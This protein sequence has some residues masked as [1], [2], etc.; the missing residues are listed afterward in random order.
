MA[1]THVCIWSGTGWKHISA[2][3][4]AR[5]HP[6][7]TVSAHSGLFMCELCG[8]YVLLTDGDIQVRHFRHSSSE[9]SKDCPE[10]T[11]GTSFFPSYR[12]NEHELPIRIS[13]IQPKRINFE[14]GLIRVPEG[15]LK[16][17]SKIEIQP[18]EQPDT[19]FVYLGE[20]IAP[21][22]ITYVG[23]GSVPY[24]QYQITITDAERSIYKYWPQNVTG[25]NPEGSIFETDTGK[26]LPYDADVKVGD[27]YYLLIAGFAKPGGK[28]ISVQEVSSF[29]CGWRNWRLYRICADDYD[30]YSAR[31]FLEYHCRLTKYP[32]SLVPIW[33]VYVEDPYVMKHSREKTFMLVNGNAEMTVFP[34]SAVRQHYEAATVMEVAA[35]NRQQLISIVRS[36]IY[37]V[38]GYTYFWQEPLDSRNPL[39][40]VTAMNIDGIPL[41]VGTH[42]KLPKHCEIVLQSAY[43]GTVLVRQEEKVIEKRTVE[44]GETVSISDL[45]YGMEINV[46]IGLDLCWSCSF[47][48]EKHENKCIQEPYQISAATFIM[49]ERIPL[50]LREESET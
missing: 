6:G 4:A 8:Q 46:L 43:D 18:A 14:L 20:R 42:S 29:R 31:F 27:E 48:R 33:P 23:I 17:A 9:K 25:I 10:R 12:K 44:A 50:L 26:K 22:Q 16:P 49:P 28:H 13:V 21:D 36:G 24:R 39:P 15:L 3:E 5:Q 40:T 30:E 47:T 38:L 19:P 37:R 7:G 32:S 1:L 45:T 41:T 11:A 34:Y 2:Y 35:N